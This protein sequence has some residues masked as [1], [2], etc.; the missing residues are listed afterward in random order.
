LNLGSVAKILAG[1][2]GLQIVSTHP[3]SAS[4]IRDLMKANIRTLV[5][6]GVISFEGI[7]TDQYKYRVS[8]LSSAAWSIQSFSDVSE[9]I[10]GYLRERRF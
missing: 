6:I 1:V 2:N 3:P 10:L 4:R 5:A 7:I 9:I 8:P